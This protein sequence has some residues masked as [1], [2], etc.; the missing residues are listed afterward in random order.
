M[1]MKTAPA[2]FAAGATDDGQLTG[3][4]TAL[5]SVFGN[6][7]VVKDRVMPGAFTTTLK[8]W[9]DT[10]API[11]VIWSHQWADPDLHIG[12]V[13]KAQETEA[14]LLVEGQ[15]DMENPKARQVAKLLAERRVKEFSFGYD[16]LAAND[17]DGVRELHAL[18]LFEVGPCLKGAN[19]ATVLVDAKT[20][21]APTPQPVADT[22]GEPKSAPESGEPGSWLPGE[23]TVRLNLLGANMKETNQ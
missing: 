13:T 20:Q 18:E 8:A 4:F 12:V 17:V 1:E 11:P 6:V 10:G 23:L 15:L 2:E 7:D 14:G 22:A 21:P 3:Q 5:V 9:E 19:P 16:V